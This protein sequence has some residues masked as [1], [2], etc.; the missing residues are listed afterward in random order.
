MTVIAL[1]ER[2][3]DPPREATCL[4]RAGLEW[5]PCCDECAA[6]WP[7][8]RKSYLANDRGAVATL[9][10]IRDHANSAEDPALLAQ[11]ELDRLK[12]P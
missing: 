10:R 1:C 2:G 12:A 8:H 5:H 7:D 9:E 11:H 6:W 3:C 4:I